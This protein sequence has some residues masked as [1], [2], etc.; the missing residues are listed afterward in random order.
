MNFVVTWTRHALRQF[1]DMWTTAT[2]PDAVDEAATHRSDID[3]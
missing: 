1:H 3:D 2:D